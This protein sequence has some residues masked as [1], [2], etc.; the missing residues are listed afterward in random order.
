MRRNAIVRVRRMFAA[1]LFA[2]FAISPSWVGQ[3]AHKQDYSRVKGILVEKDAKSPSSVAEPV[4]G[5]A[6]RNVQTPAALH[7]AVATLSS[8]IGAG[9]A[10]KNSSR[11]TF[12]RRKLWTEKDGWIVR[13]V[14]VCS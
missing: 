9:P 13:R 10:E 7:R 1:F 6:R 14:P 5:R 4:R 2:A 11:C 3:A 12:V 8:A